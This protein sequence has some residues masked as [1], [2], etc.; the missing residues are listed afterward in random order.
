MVYL[1][2]A[3]E[4]RERRSS[5]SPK[6]SLNFLVLLDDPRMAAGAL[7]AKKNG[8]H[9]LRRTAASARLPGGVDIR[10]LADCLGNADPGLPSGRTHT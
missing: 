1:G 3:A 9:V 4:L 7:A 5:G 8:M 2:A 6:I 10:T